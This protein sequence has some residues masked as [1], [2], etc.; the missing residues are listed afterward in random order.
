MKY[1]RSVIPSL[2]QRFFLAS[3]ELRVFIFTLMLSVLCCVFTSICIY[4]SALWLLLCTFSVHQW[5]GSCVDLVVLSLWDYLLSWEQLEKAL[6]DLLLS[7]YYRGE[8]WHSRHRF[9]TDSLLGV[10][11]SAPWNNQSIP[12]SE[13]ALDS[14]IRRWNSSVQKLS[15]FSILH[16][17]LGTECSLLR[18]VLHFH[19]LCIG[20][21]QEWVYP[22]LGSSRIQLWSQGSPT[23][24]ILEEFHDGR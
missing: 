16:E 17:R 23:L 1:T 7:R 21:S 19:F 4:D 12:F 22:W 14:L 9:G 5:A 10:F 24:S 20:Q 11:G 8:S 13:K 15:D 6:S 3:V 18:S 2:H